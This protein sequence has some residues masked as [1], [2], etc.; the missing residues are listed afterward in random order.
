[1]PKDRNPFWDHIE[2]VDGRWKCKYCEQ[3]FSLKVSVSRI[4]AH[5][6][7]VS[8]HGVEVCRNAP[9]AV[10]QKAYEAIRSKRQKVMPPVLTYDQGQAPENLFVQDHRYNVPEIPA[11]NDALNTLWENT[12]GEMQPAATMP[13]STNNEARTIFPAE[14]EDARLAE[15][16]WE[17]DARLV[18]EDWEQ[19]A[20]LAEEDWES[21]MQHLTLFED[22]VPFARLMQSSSVEDV[23]TADPTTAPTETTQENQVQ[24][25]SGNRWS[26]S[27]RLSPVLRIS[28]TSLMLK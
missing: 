24:D 26:G 21:T 14:H 3:T 11:E 13:S 15:E 5:L 7:G 4:K 20:R 8:S 6:S 1:M 22:Q 27:V 19:Y 2:E 23:K 10:V 12:A 28:S 25:T 16:D 18:Y 9:A 17:Q